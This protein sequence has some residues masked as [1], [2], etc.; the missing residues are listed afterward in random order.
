MILYVRATIRAGR[1]QRRI[2]ERLVNVGRETRPWGR[3]LTEKNEEK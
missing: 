1:E 3:R 2:S